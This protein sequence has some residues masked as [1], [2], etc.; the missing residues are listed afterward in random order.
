MEVLNWSEKPITLYFKAFQLNTKFDE[1][2]VIFFF[3]YNGRLVLHPEE[4]NVEP[5]FNNSCTL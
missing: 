3:S 5:L 2:N 1:L 4:S